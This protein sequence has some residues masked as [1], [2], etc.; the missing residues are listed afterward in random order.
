MSKRCKDCGYIGESKEFYHI[1]ETVGK[2]LVE[3]YTC[4]EC[5][6]ENITESDND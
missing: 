4:P 3:V 5:D 1:E 6:S 2:Q